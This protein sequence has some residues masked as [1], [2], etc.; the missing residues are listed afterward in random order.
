MHNSFDSIVVGAGIAGSSCAIQLAEKGARTLLLDR[1]CFPRHKTC[2]EFLSPESEEILDHLGIQLHNHVPKPT[3]MSSAKLIMPHG[4]ELDATLPGFAT[5]ISRYELDCILHEKAVEAGCER[6]THATVTAIRQRS[7]QTYEV[8]T[9]QNGKTMTYHSK[10]VIG[11]HGTKKVRGSRVSLDARDPQTYVGFKSHFNGLEVPSRVE[12]YFCDGGYVGLSPIENGK[13]NVAALMA[14]DVVQGS[15]KTVLE[16]LEVASR[17]N[18]KLAD[19]LAGAEPVPDTQVGVCPIHLSNIPDPWADYPQIGD[20]LLMIPPLCGDG[21]SI[22]L[23]SSLLAANWTMLYL[24]GEID[25]ENWRMGYIN[26]ANQEFT[27]LLRR[28]RRIQKLA[29]AR[30]NRF[31]PL[32]ARVVPGFSEYMVKATRLPRMKIT[33]KWMEAR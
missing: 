13:T 3:K 27:S 31:Y 19:R 23:R 12:L 16:M 33:Q 8:E 1:Q 28:A 7:D 17:G 25:Y 10:T 14:L 4:G 18:R 5:G 11:A 15:G 24:Q 22:A 26:A 21:M 2:G 29:F 32:L 9:K 30:T 20:A 6:L